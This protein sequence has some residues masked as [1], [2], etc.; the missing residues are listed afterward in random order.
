LI[1]CDLVVSSSAKASGTYRKGMRAVVNTAEMPTGDVVRFRDADLASP[2]RL[3]A[4]EQVI[5]KGNLATVD[6]N[7]LAEELLGDSVYANMLMLG[8]AW[9]EGLVPV[10]LAG[11]E[12]AIELNGVA[13]MRNKQAFAWGRVA[14]AAPDFLP[15]SARSVPEVETLDEMIARRSAFLAHY[16]NSA[17]AKRYE[18]TIAR[19][20]RAET[21]LASE[22]LTDAVA[23]SLFRLMAYKDEY[24][25]ARLHMESGF[26]D[27]LRQQFEGD[28]KIRYHLA[29]P[30]LPARK[31]ARGRPRKRSFGPWM[32][33][34]MK[35]LA[36]LRVLR[37]TR[38]DLFGYT[39]ERRHERE[40]IA[41]YEALIE[42][43]LAKLNAQN[44][45]DLLAIAR[46][47]MEIRGYGPVKEL[48]IPQVRTEVAR[49]M[50]HL[51]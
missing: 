35:L 34:P 36:R 40:L 51:A 9:Q 28:F 50:A 29:P 38:F 49:L 33:V 23:R 31:D 17:Y 21:A 47:P 4:I 18:A 13:V 11:L 5:G 15:R 7:A 42:A 27:E 6:A 10:S 41:W 46:A 26:L 30:F 12:R 22:A 48:A 32:Q 45:P 44:L 39:A 2:T 16:Q 8:F 1:G 25:V 24:E 19:V 43:M 14:R 20:R 3:R 37:G